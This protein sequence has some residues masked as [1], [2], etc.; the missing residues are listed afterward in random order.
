VR[1]FL[2]ATIAVHVQGRPSGTPLA[3][4]TVR[5]AAGT[6]VFVQPTDSNGDVLFSQ[7][8]PNTLYTYSSTLFGRTTVSGLTTMSPAAG[9][10]K[11]V[12]VE[13]TDPAAPSTLLVRVFDS[14]NARIGSAA[15]RVTGPSPS[16]ADVA[17][18][19]GS[20]SSNGE[21][22][23]SVADGQYSITVSKA[24]YNGQTRVVTIAGAASTQDFVLTQGSLNGSFKVTVKDHDGHLISGAR[25]RL[26]YPDGSYSSTRQY[27]GSNGTFTWSDLPPGSGYV[28]RWRS[29]EGEWQSD[30]A[31][32]IS[33]GQ[34]TLWT[35]TNYR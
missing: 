27:T 11:A 4:A 34:E 15:V 28:F 18:S 9:Q 12:L 8:L 6:S 10:S 21:I 22:S 13:M 14:N 2:A 24:S 20:T 16:T 35:V 29:G 25:V 33:P 32:S 3:G 31:V 30:V 19:P 7:L 17:G 26:I 5:L 1:G 23:F